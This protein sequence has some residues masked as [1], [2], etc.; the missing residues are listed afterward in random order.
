MFDARVFPESLENA[1]KIL[2]KQGVILKG[3]YQIHDFIFA[4]VDPKQTLDK[5]FLRLRIVPV[6]IWNEKRVIVAVKNTELQKV[7]KKSIIPI[8]EQFDT[9][10]EARI[11]IDKNYSEKFKPDFDFDRKGWQYDLPNGDQVDLEDIEGRFSIEFKS[12]TEHGLQKLLELFEV[13]PEDVVKGPSVVVVR[14][15][16]KTASF[17]R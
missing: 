9:E 16:L 12:K 5:V 7:G 11:F 14:D 3:E 17:I 2:E 8:K 13:N 6:N 4:S 10:S 1:K 15:R